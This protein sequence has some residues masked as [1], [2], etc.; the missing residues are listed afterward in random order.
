MDPVF[1]TTNGQSLV[2]LDF[3]GLRFGKTS[4]GSFSNVFY[5]RRKT[6][7]DYE[8]VLL[9]IPGAEPCFP[10]QMTD[11]DCPKKPFLSNDVD[12]CC[13][14]KEPPPRNP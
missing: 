11:H 14:T 3:L 9:F 10:S 4:F 13:E 7:A 1:P 12:I 8:D 6:C 5:F 2:G